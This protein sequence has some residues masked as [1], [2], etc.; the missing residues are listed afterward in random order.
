MA[1]KANSCFFTNNIIKKKNSFTKTKSNSSKICIFK[2]FYIFKLLYI[3]IIFI[4][5][6][7]LFSFHLHFQSSSSLA[8][9]SYSC[10]IR[11][12]F[13]GFRLYDITLALK[14]YKN[15]CFVVLLLATFSS[16]GTI[17]NR[18]AFPVQTN[19]LQNT[20]NK[21]PGR[22]VMHPAFANAGRAPGLEIWRVEV[23]FENIFTHLEKFRF[24]NI[25]YTT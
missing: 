8:L 21:S 24:I 1:F 9:C 2:L 10:W 22:R 14:C 17:P 7:F 6:F 12:D 20:G 11:I 18:P 19:Q 25:E 23:S 3:F 16:A 4:K 15:S 5:F 13:L